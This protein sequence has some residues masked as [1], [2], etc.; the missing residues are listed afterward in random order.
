M[1]LLAGGVPN[2]ADLA[3]AHAAW[4]SYTPV[5]TATSSNPALVNG[6]LTGAYMKIG[7]TVLVR[8][9]LTAG[10]STTFGS[11]GW[12]LSLPLN[13]AADQVLSALVRDNSTGTHWTAV[14]WITNADG[15]F[16]VAAGANVA[17]VA[18][19]VPMSWAASDQLFI[20]GSYESS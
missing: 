6:T 17:A 4:T 16:R 13:P 9:L 5:W 15:V 7:K 20:S 1:S 19:A 3:F 14:A 11:G 10:S 8:I 18:A 2:A 12:K